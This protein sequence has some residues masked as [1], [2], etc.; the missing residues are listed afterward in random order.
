MLKPVMSRAKR[1]EIVGGA[2]SSLGDM[3]LMMRFYPSGGLALLLVWVAILRYIAIFM[4]GQKIK[5]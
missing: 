1:D 5:N 3:L 2:Q 4:S